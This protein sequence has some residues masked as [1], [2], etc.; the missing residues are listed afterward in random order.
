MPYRKNSMLPNIDRIES[1]ADLV[2]WAKAVNMSLSP[3]DIPDAQDIYAHSGYN[4][5]ARFF[6]EAEGDRKLILC[7]VHNV[8]PHEEVERLLKALAQHKVNKEMEYYYAEHEKK[9]TALNARINAFQDV[10]KPYHKKLE[11]LRRRNA[12]LER[13]FQAR[14]DRE[15]G[16]LQMIRQLRQEVLGLTGKAQKYDA[17]AAAVKGLVET[18]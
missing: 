17:I 9:E 8:M 15:N 11:T 12:E 16:L 18:A 1:V 4:D 5:I 13:M 7:S 14:N 6:I 10:M 2:A 3:K